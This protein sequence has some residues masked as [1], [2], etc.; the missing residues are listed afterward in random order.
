M[1]DFVRR[2]MFGRQPTS[3]DAVPEDIARALDASAED[4][5]NDR[6]EDLRDFVKRKKAE[7]EAHLAQ[8]NSNKP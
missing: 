7:L 5:R 3:H 8:K 6:T 4:V 1:V 2:A